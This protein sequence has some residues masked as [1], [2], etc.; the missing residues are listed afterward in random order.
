MLGRIAS[1]VKNGGI[2]FSATSYKTIC[3]SPWL[4]Y[5]R[6]FVN[7]SAANSKVSFFLQKQNRTCCEPSAG[8]L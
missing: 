4:C 3:E 2:P 8:S 6:S 7:R 1:Q 5:Q